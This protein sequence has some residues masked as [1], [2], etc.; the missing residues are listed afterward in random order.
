MRTAKYCLIKQM[1]SDERYYQHNTL[2]VLIGYNIYVNSF[3]DACS[4]IAQDLLIFYSKYCRNTDDR[5]YDCWRKLCNNSKYILLSGEYKQPKNLRAFEYIYAGYGNYYLDKNGDIDDV[6]FLSNE[7]LLLSDFVYKAIRKVINKEKIDVF[8][9][10]PVQ[11]VEVKAK[12][13]WNKEH[14][15]SHHSKSMHWA[16]PRRRELALSHDPEVREY[17]DARD[18]FKG[19]FWR[20]KGIRHNR[21]SYIPGDWKHYHKCRKQWAKNI[22]NPSYEKLSKAVW[23]RELLEEEEY[24]CM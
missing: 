15:V 2:G 4:Y 12:A 11:K 8:Y 16:L 14:P 17:L 23:K 21:H 20:H 22:E 13:M 18:M 9:S 3:Q 10:F 6:K 5:W 7:N 1:N 19:N 24:I